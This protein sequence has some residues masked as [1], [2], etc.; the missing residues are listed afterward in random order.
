MRFDSKS[1][2]STIHVSHLEFTCRNIA[3]W[4]PANGFRRDGIPSTLPIEFLG[5]GFFGSCYRLLDYP[6]LVI[7]MCNYSYDGYP[8]YIRQVAKLSNPKAW[9]PK[10]FMY[11]GDETSGVFWCVLPEYTNP[12]GHEGS[13]RAAWGA[14]GTWILHVNDTLNNGWLS[15]RERRQKIRSLVRERGERK[16]AMQLMEFLEPMCAAGGQVY[17]HAKN[18]LR[19][20]NRWVVTDPIAEWSKT[21]KEF[22]RN[23]HS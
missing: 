6:G 18:A 20:G 16:Q 12:W 4:A 22:Y 23:A 3:A 15:A 1:L 8:E 17:L 9:M 19:D 7:K 13:W 5:G 10:V 21:D 2:L 11:E 14:E